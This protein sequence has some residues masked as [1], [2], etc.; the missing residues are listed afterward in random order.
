MMVPIVLTECPIHDHLGEGRQVIEKVHGGSGE[1]FSQ[2][3]LQM[4]DY[5]AINERAIG[6]TGKAERTG[7][8]WRG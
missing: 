7:S 6:P 2:A 5:N 4:A 1:Q 3:L 8:A